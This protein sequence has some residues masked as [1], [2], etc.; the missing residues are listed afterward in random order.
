MQ[1]IQ[2]WLATA[3]GF[4]ISGGEPFDQ[5]SALKMLLRE[6]RNRHPGDVL[7]YSGYP[8][9]SLPLPDFDGLID[10]LISDPLDIDADQTLPLRGSDNQRLHLLTSLG[11]RKFSDALLPRTDQNHALDIMFDDRTGEVFMAGIPRR[12]D[13]LRLRDALQAGG[14]LVATTEDERQSR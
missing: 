10:A 8:V 7:V 6:I 5:A 12:G 13:L 2:G 9:E 14:H 1:T 4:S 11:Q 3:D